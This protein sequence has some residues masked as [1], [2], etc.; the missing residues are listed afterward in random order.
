M[1]LED[2][3]VALL[4][5]CPRQLEV[6]GRASAGEVIPPIG[7]QDLSNIQEK[8]RHRSRSF[9]GSSGND[10]CFLGGSPD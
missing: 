5:L 1:R 7:E 6:F 4:H 2:Q 9:H 10:V 8:C 3:T